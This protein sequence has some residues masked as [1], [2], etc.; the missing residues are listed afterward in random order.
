[1]IGEESSPIK[2]NVT[3][4]DFSTILQ[5]V[6]LMMTLGLA[7]TGITSFI[8][9]N[10]LNILAF[11]LETWSIWLIAELALVIIL[12]FNIKKMGAGT[13]TLTFFLYAIVNG[14]TLST[15][16]LA[17][18]YSSIASTF[19]I[20]AGMF[21]AAAIYGKVTNKDLTKFGSFL[22]MALFGLI[23]ASVV[24][25]FIQNDMFSFIVSVIGILIFIGLTAYDVQKIKA[26]SEEVG[27]GDQDKFTQIVTMGAL[28]LYLD[29]IN[30]FLKLLRLLGKRKN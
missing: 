25:I 13:C 19:F 15:I 7:V 18:T 27:T 5:K 29:L 14:L 30:I 9:A 17:Y 22:I 4:Y 28:T 10:N 21:G 16:F 20:T 26:I 24:N 8:V 2:E 3:S 1:M 23:I 11:V 6:F 12:S